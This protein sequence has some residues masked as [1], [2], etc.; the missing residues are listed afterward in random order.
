[1][2]TLDHWSLESTAATALSCLVTT[3]RVLPAS[4]S[5]TQVDIVNVMIL[6]RDSSRLAGTFPVKHTSRLSP[7]QRITLRPPSMAALVLRATNYTEQ[8]ERKISPRWILSST[9]PIKAHPHPQLCTCEYYTSSSSFRMV[10]RSLCP[11]KVQL[12]FASRS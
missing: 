9:A 12:T 5:Y 7:M 6:R 3:S 2:T 11:I 8:K 10:L 1:M 4:R